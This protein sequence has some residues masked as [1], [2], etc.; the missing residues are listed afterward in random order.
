MDWSRFNETRDDVGKLISCFEPLQR[1]KH[2]EYAALLNLVLYIF[3][4]TYV[5]ITLFIFLLK[6]YSNPYLM[7]KNIK[8][9]LISSFG[10]M[11]VSWTLI[12][13]SIGRHLFPCIVFTV[14]VFVSF[15]SKFL[16]VLFLSLSFLLLLFLLLSI[17]N[18]WFISTPL[19]TA[20]PIVARLFLYYNKVAYSKKLEKIS[21]ESLQE[22]QFLATLKVTIESRRELSKDSS[23]PVTITDTKE[24]ISPP[25]SHISANT[26]PSLAQ[27]TRTDTANSSSGIKPLTK[28]SIRN[29]LSEMG[30]ST[31][32]KVLSAAHQNS[33]SFTSQS[34][35]SRS[36]FPNLLNSTI[37]KEILGSMLVNTNDAQEQ[38][39]SLA[40]LSHFNQ[41]AQERYGIKLTIAVL[42]P[43]VIALIVVIAI[44]PPLYSGCVG[45]VTR[46]LE[47]SVLGAE[48]IIIA[49]FAAAGL[50]FGRIQ[51]APDP[52]FELRELRL[53]ISTGIVL[54]VIGVCLSLF[55]PGS[56]EMEGVITYSY[57][58]VAGVFILHNI[59]TVL[60]LVQLY[61]ATRR[62]QRNINDISTSSEFPDY[63]YWQYNRRYYKDGGSFSKL[64]KFSSGLLHKSTNSLDPQN[65]LQ[66]KEDKESAP[67]KDTEKHRYGSFGPNGEYLDSALSVL[68]HDA[69][70]R[71][72]FEDYVTGEF[73]PEG[74]RFVTACEEWINQYETATPKERYKSALQIYSLFIYDGSI[75]QVNIRSEF[76]G[77]LDQMFSSGFGPEIVTKPS[78]V[79]SFTKRA[80]G[81]SLFAGM[82]INRFERQA[83]SERPRRSIKSYKTTVNEALQEVMEQRRMAENFY[84]DL[85]KDL[86]DD[87]M[88]EVFML[89][90][91]DSYPRFLE[92]YEYRKWLSDDPISAGRFPQGPGNRL[93][94]APHPSAYRSILS[95]TKVQRSS[96]MGF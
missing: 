87:A 26:R 3:Y 68:M 46:V 51:S 12:R 45:C 59:Q 78:E 30:N 38:S 55:D 80:G 95:P 94:T 13:E 69:V 49:I 83:S 74:P 9:I 71:V 44:S 92:S 79:A 6:S 11:I 22:A 25:S 60:P 50:F 63:G 52:L 82:A 58:A 33:K 67:T 16:L 47:E 1:Y 17:N 36:Q 89:M 18:I 70:G 54:I 39:I 53:C 29:L 24:M 61:L 20:M 5:I 76:R 10:G 65:S 2:P 41:A 21:L 42:L 14:F 8:L 72:L 48:V 77:R 66:S 43:F 40:K 75:L 27:R 81:N 56:F 93:I 84:I 19:V 15:P 91:I 32:F 7:K 37:A 90:A 73:S 64:G 96:K 34:K 85:P 57:I 62:L 88:D 35:S 31:R 28:S 23:L 86:F 4:N